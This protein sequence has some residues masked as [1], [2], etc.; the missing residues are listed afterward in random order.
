[1]INKKLKKYIEDN[2]F[3]HYKNDGS[4]HGLD[5]IKYV[6]DRSMRFA[7][8]LENINFDMVYVI[9]AY[10]D[11]AHSIDAKNHEKLSATMLLNDTNLLEF[12][13]KDEICV[14]SEAV[15]DHRASIKGEPRSIYG[16]IVS[17]ADR[18][19]NIEDILRR[20]YL[21]RISH[22][23]DSSLDEIINESFNHI[24]EKFG[25]SGYA[26]K[27]MYFNDIEYDKFLDEVELLVFDKDLFEE[28]YCKV[29][30]LVK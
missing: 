15:Y 26:S 14:M 27:K 7:K 2:I 18:N 8:D 21:Y 25:K 13:S 6:I 23:P 20:T 4:G 29:N 5:H 24:R 10:H 30:N 17:S 19:T 1:M 28:K 22:F 9:A 12:F 16:K 11:I 3:F